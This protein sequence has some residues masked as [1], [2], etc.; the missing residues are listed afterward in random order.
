MCPAC[1]IIPF[2]STQIALHQTIGNGQTG[3]DDRD[4]AHQLDQDVEAGAGGVFERVADRIAYDCRFMGFAAFAAM[5]SFFDM[6]LGI[7]P[8]SS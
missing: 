3:Y 6:F 7:V 1:Q 4:H 2:Y 5:V 8:G